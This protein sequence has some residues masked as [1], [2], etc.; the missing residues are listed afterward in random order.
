MSLTIVHL[1]DLQFGMNHRFFGMK[2]D[3]GF[4]ADRNESDSA[5]L[6]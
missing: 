6:K 1:S 5:G 4:A 3:I 2:W